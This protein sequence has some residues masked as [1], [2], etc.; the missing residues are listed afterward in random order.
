[1]RIKTHGALFVLAATFLVASALPTPANAEPTAHERASASFQQARAAFA[2]RE[3]TAAAAAFEQAAEYEPHPVAWLNAA[4][5]W[6]RADDAVRAASDCDHVLADPNAAASYRTEAESRLKTLGQ[7]VATVQIRG[8]SGTVASLDGGANFSL[9]AQKRMTAGAHTV[10]VFDGSA[11]RRF[12]VHV[13]LGETKE[14]ETALPSSPSTATGDPPAGAGGTPSALAKPTVLAAPAKSSKPPPT[15]TWIAFGVSGA[16]LAC[17]GIFGLRTASARDDFSSSP[18]DATRDAFYRER[19]VTNASLGVALVAAGA[20]LT[21]WLLS[22]AKTRTNLGGAT[23]FEGRVA[24][25]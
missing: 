24:S 15:A 19:L 13:G 9:P 18:T 16:A 5:A 4:E 21:I 14:L 6:A 7:R 23:L 25:W 10:T 22:P 3:F 1:M 17:A 12:E 20:G 11:P 8:R 2:R